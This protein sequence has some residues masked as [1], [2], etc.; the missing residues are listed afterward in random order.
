MFDVAIFGSSK[1]DGST[2]DPGEW[3]IS[4]SL[5]GSSELDFASTPPAPAVEVFIFTLFGGARVKVRPEQEVR[6]S[7]F[8]LFGGRHIDPLRLSPPAGLAPPGHPDD[9][10][11]YS[12]PLHISAYSVFGGVNVKR[13]EERK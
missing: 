12:E 3:V 4:L 1:V 8:S 11:D 5:F 13:F 2:V 6:V 10:D 7:G 9:A